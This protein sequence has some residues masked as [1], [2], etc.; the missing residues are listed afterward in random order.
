[1]GTA[2]SFT[3]IIIILGTKTRQRF[4]ASAENVKVDIGPHTRKETT[5]IKKAKSMPTSSKEMMNL[6][7]PGATTG[8]TSLKP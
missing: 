7:S 6:P 5:Q 1:M 8:K 4:V 3:D 2:A